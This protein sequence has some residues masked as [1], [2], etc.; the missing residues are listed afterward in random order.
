MQKC[1]AIY[2]Y[3]WKARKNCPICC[4]DCDVADI[5]SFSARPRHCHPHT[6][7]SFSRVFL[8]AYRKRM[9]HVK[10]ATYSFSTL[11]FSWDVFLM[12]RSESH[13][14]FFSFSRTTTTKCDPRGQAFFLRFNNYEK[15]KVESFV[16]SELKRNSKSWFYFSFIELFSR[17]IEW[18]MI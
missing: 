6:Q 15:I 1:I 17:I 11:N 9:W 13:C 12:T 18:Q 14:F 3:I 10:L 8:F 2:I 4:G 16:S 7:D 5:L